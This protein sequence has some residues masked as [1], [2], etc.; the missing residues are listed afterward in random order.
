MN[1]LLYTTA[2]ALTAFSISNNSNAQELTRNCNPEAYYQARDLV[3]W[4]RC[5]LLKTFGNENETWTQ[6]VKRYPGY[7]DD[8]TSLSIDVNG[9][10]LG[11][12][13]TTGMKTNYDF[14]NIA[15]K[16]K[17]LNEQFDRANGNIK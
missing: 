15:R 7:N 13:L 12:K 6:L 4:R 1:K 16:V 9:R 5:D 2:I 17:E 14:N 8:V 10:I 11:S 3:S